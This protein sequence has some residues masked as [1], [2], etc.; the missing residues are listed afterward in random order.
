MV[1]IKK[2][3]MVG[4]KTFARKT[5][6][7]FDKGLNVIVGPNGSGKSNIVDAI[8]F[9]LGE[10]S[11]R[12]LRATSNFSSLLFHGNGEVPRARYATVTLHLNN[13]DRKIPVDTDVVTISRHIGSDGT[14]IYKVNGKKY[15]RST[16]L[17]LLGVASL[18][19]S[20]NI[21]FQG[22]TM[23]I[24]DYSP[25]E[26]RENIENIIGISEYDKKKQEAREQ[27]REAETNIKVAQGK[28]EEIKKR[29]IE[30]ERERNDLLRYNY[31]KNQ[32]ATLKAN[33]L[34][35]RIQKLD[36]ELERLK[37]EVE[38]R[39]RQLSDYRLQ[40]ER[41]EAERH[42]RQK[43]MHEYTVRVV[44]KGG[45]QLV[46]I[47]SQIGDINS[48]IAGLKTTISSAQ[49]NL[50]TLEVMRLEKME[51]LKKLRED[52]VAVRRERARLIRA[53]N[54]IQALLSQ[55]EKAAEQ[56]KGKIWEIKNSL[57]ENAA[58]LSSLE[59]ET[60]KL[61]S[62]LA[63][64]HVKIK[65][66]KESVNVLTDQ[67]QV[68][69]S[70]KAT[71]ENLH[72]SFSSRLKEVNGLKQKEQ[73][74]YQEV[75]A[76]IERIKTQREIAEA[77]ISKADKIAK[78]A[79]VNVA[80]FE[81]RRN[82]ADSVLSEEKAL[83]H[84]EGLAEL[85]ALSG[86]HGR[87]AGKI[88]IAA[89][90][91]KAVEAA[92]EGWLQALI[93]E[94]LEV[95][96][97]CADSLKRAKIGRVKLL[98]L[99]SLEKVRSVGKP[100][101]EGI[102]GSAASFV[103]CANKFRPAVNFVL[104]DTL[105][106]VDGETALQ[107]SAK[108]YRVV[109]V[110]G[111]VYEP[112]IRLEVG[113]YREP[114][115][116]SDV[117]PS[118]ET[119]KMLNETVASFERL[120]SRRQADLKHLSEELIRLEG[121]KVLREDTIKFL[122]REAAGL[123]QN[124]ERAHKSI[125]E[126]NRRIRSFTHRRDKLQAEIEGAEARVAQIEQR[127]HK[128]RVEAANIRKKLKPETMTKLEG[129]NAELESEISEYHRRLNEINSQLSSN[130]SNLEH[131]YLPSLKTGKRELSGIEKN[132]RKRREEIEVAKRRMEEAESKLKSLQR[133]KENFSAMMT[134]KKEE[135]RKFEE[136]IENINKELQRIEKRCEP[137]NEEI[138]GLNQR[139]L[140][141]QLE[142]EQIINELKSLGYEQPREVSVEEERVSEG[143]FESFQREH[144][145]L[146]GRL[147]MNA[148]ALYPTHMKTYKELS[149]KIN[150]LEE[151]KREI[152]TFMEN[153]EREKRDAFFSALEK[154]NQKFSETFSAITNG[155]GWIQLQ[156]PDE[157]F[158]EGLDIIVE[159]PGKPPMPVAAASGGE[160]SVVAVCY[161]FA[162]QSLTK[163]SP[164]YILDEIDAHLDSVNA[165]RLAELLARESKESQMIVISFKDTVA[166]KADKIFGV[167]VKNGISYLH[168]LPLQ[169]MEAAS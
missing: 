35:V 32:L 52:A 23:K 44:D 117:I 96:R 90:Y 2:L 144:D 131:V 106:A 40:K 159:F 12:A 67:L 80:E 142:R 77:E 95:V 69:N 169:V 168:S 105:V 163:T 28:Y 100:P 91:R 7:T 1:T 8:Q 122:E 76:A 124:M 17:D 113:F 10:L 141:H 135:Y 107:A 75:L 94:N 72:E 47:Q 148:A 5:S 4:F 161:I 81:S 155:K 43:D 14:S 121:E 39:S 6:I 30:L 49:T 66:E 126:L 136:E 79:R 13:Q 140:R 146:Y 115:D 71:F 160:K 89:G 112:G 26:R 36:E 103:E 156:N 133:E 111:E 65:A 9:V 125:V 38:D 102:L 87:L 109:T 56:I 149:T 33:R 29:V 45:D 153:V 119:V 41:L 48:E 150:Q 157:P 162:L 128:L 158:S 53:R 164:F 83:A 19:G 70:R 46:S 93:V 42:A 51:A 108:G 55:K 21:I 64:L 59:E 84:I 123:T 98:P 25:E 54:Q 147:N 78:R 22:T 20:M 92:A 129:E 18:T 134:T 62:E 31:V 116:L 120:L 139:I 50:K 154:L 104:G 132:I 61:E 166:A 34:S 143:L 114:I 37:K 127:L 86:V 167:Y 152:L 27:L 16:L 85:K 130:E 15:S 101:I 151:E 73:K 74:G 24:A 3:E 68:L 88:R 58:K 165:S 63:R 82:L 110:E 57:D 145:R 11:W 138:N 97:R 99:A 118:G 60:R 137:L